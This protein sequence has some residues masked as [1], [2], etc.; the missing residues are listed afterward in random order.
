MRSIIGH[1]RYFAEGPAGD[2][3]PESAAA[4]DNGK[5]DD[6]G[7]VNGSANG[8][9]AKPDAKQADAKASD[10]VDGGKKNEGSRPATPADDNGV[11]ARNGSGNKGRN[12]GGQ[13]R[14]P[15]GNGQGKK[16]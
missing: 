16:K 2:K 1:S 13:Q 7:P 12:G 9:E 11:G 14:N 8:A 10:G 4:A 3:Q 6:K 5:A 15:G